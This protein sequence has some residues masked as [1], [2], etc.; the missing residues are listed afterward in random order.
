[1]TDLHSYYDI[2]TILAPVDP[3]VPGVGKH[4]DHS[5]PFAKPRR[6]WNKG[7][8]KTYKTIY[9]QPMSESKKQKFG[10]WIQKQNFE[11]IKSAKTSTDKVNIFE[12]LFRENIDDIFPKKMVKI[13]D[14][15]KEWMTEELR[16]LRRQKS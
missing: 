8:Q 1:M 2:P 5:T 14:N 13:Y 15:D 12:Q 16:Q 4:S 9:V 6:N 11:E 3:D 7:K 10:L